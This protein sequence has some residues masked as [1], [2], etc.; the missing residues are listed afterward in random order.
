MSRHLTIG[1]IFAVALSLA[2]CTSNEKK[3]PKA[4]PAS[5]QSSVPTGMARQADSVYAYVDEVRSDLSDGK[6]ELINDV[7]RLTPEE[8]KT[9]WPIY[10]DYEDELFALGDQRVEMSKAYVTAM[11]SNTLDDPK[12]AQLANDWFNFETQRLDLLKKYHKQ[13]AEQ[14]SPIRAAQFVQIENRVGNVIDLMIA[15]ELPIM[16]GRPVPATPAVPAKAKV[17]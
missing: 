3:E 1:L 12:A 17:E 11:T 10:H 13:I 7:M 9:F 2:A 14:L 16:K 6:T 5:A 15:S 8:S 4:A